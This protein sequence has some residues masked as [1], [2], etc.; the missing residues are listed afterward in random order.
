METNTY[1]KGSVGYLR[2]WRKENNI[3]VDVYKEG[4]LIFV[5][6]IFDSFTT[7]MSIESVSICE[8]KDFVESRSGVQGRWQTP[9]VINCFDYIGSE[10]FTNEFVFDKKEVKPGDKV[11]VVVT[12]DYDP[13][14]DSIIGVFTEE[15]NKEDIL[16]K[17]IKHYNSLLPKDDYCN[18]LE[19]DEL[20]ISRIFEVIVS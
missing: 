5:K 14:G 9:Y 19:D 6:E 11:Y 13:Y 10:D 2:E 4:T 8:D 3:E 18:L 12:N 15:P 1:P 20:F 7:S 17:Y 16:E